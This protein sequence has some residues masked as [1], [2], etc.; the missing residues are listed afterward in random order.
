MWTVQVCAVKRSPGEHHSHHFP[1]THHST[2][3][4]ETVPDQS[5]ICEDQTL[6]DLQD[7]VLCSVLL[8]SQQMRARRSGHGATRT[9]LTSGNAGIKSRLLD[10]MA[11]WKHT[12][13]QFIYKLSHLYEFSKCWNWPFLYLKRRSSSCHKKETI[14]IQSVFSKR[15]PQ[16]ALSCGGWGP[17][18]QA[19]SRT[20]S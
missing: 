7:E 9:W 12:A 5:S 10:E 1:W 13:C 3:R 8:P 11:P 6:S 18:V 14:H 16:T 17:H 4:M 19:L 2:C 15:L 20:V